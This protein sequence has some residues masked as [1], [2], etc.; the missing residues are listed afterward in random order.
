M[1]HVTALKGP[2]GDELIHYKSAGVHSYMPLTSLLTGT[3]IDL[4]VT[5]LA[6][7]FKNKN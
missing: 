1:V 4:T 6:V 2:V 3:L 5:E 7:Q